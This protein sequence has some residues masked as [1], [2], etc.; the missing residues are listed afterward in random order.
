M[1]NTKVRQL[2]VQETMTDQQITEVIESQDE[3]T[4][5]QNLTE[6]EVKLLIDRG[7]D[8]DANIKY[9][10]RQLK[11]IKLGVLEYAR[12]NKLKTIE[13][14]RATAKIS[15]STTTTTGTVTEFA[16]LLKKEG[17]IELFDELTKVQLTEAKKY[18]GEAALKGFLSKSIQKFAKIGFKARR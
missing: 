16:K 7:S 14:Q 18:L 9:L 1:A 11:A 17:K 8:I 3:I 6:S 10:T 15:D 2:K 5:G 13:G 4:I 12:R